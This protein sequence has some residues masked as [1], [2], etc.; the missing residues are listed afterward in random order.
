VRINYKFDD[1]N[2]PA[3]MRKIREDYEKEIAEAIMIAT[4]QTSKGAKMYAPVDKRVGHG[5]GLKAS[6]RPS[7]EGKTG[8]VTVGAGYG[9]YVEY[10]TGN[11]VNVPGELKDYAIQFKG[12]GIRNVN[13]R[14]QPYLYPSF[15]LNREKF[16]KD[17]DKRI[18]K[19]GNKN[20]R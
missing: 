8:E 14:P 4:R 15:F 17:M 16:I 10:G 20:W 13:N 11:R 5:G 12:A 3:T 6:I 9:P 19:I 18:D 7:Y 2:F 1:A